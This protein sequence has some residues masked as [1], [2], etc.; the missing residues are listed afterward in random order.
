MY[1]WR[2]HEIGNYRDVLQ[3]EQ[4]SAPALPEPGVII[5]VTAAALNFPDMLLI[6]GRY[7]VRPPLPFVPGF[8]AAGVVV[9]ASPES[10]FAVGDRIIANGQGAYAERMAVDED[11]CFPM[12]PHMSDAEGAALPIIYQTAYFGL[13]YRAHLSAG[14]TLLV[15]GGAGGVGTAAIQVGKALGARV[16]ATAG[17]EKKL[18]VCRDAGASH[19]INYREQD[20]V[21]VVKELTDGKGA[22]VIYDPVGGDVF[23]R[24][25]KCLAFSGRLMPVGFAS[26]SVPQIPA[27]RVLIKNYSVVGVHWGAY[28]RHDPE[29]IQT[30][31]TRLCELYADGHIKPVIYGQRPMRELP[32]ALGLLQDRKSFG[33]II[34]TP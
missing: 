4:C 30:T 11:H 10:R 27:N 19:V 29:L 15:H 6:A 20:F 14:E 2:V 26:G 21:P 18:Q 9:E 23:A 32:D 22:N 5:E 31:H 12:P 17:S 13:S 16:I 7:Q 24:S 28:F 1:A 3:W 33:K 25:D 34:V 8:E